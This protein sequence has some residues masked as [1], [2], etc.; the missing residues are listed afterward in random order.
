MTRNAIPVPLQKNWIGDRSPD[1][2]H[3]FSKQVGEDPDVLH[4]RL[5]KECPVALQQSEVGGLNEG[6]LVTRYEDITAVAADTETFGQSIRWPEQRRPPLESNPPEHRAFRALMQPFFMPRALAAFEPLSTELAVGLLEPL[7]AAGGGDLATEVARPLPPQVLLARL[8]APTEDWSG[9]KDA[10]EAAFL[11]GAPSPE[12][13][14]HYEQA[15]GFLW[16]Y[17]RKLV[18]ERIAS[19]R[20]SKSDLVS[21]VLAGEIDGEPVDRGLVE[22]MVRLVLAAGHDST[23]S[24]LG[25]CLKYLA[26][27]QDAQESLRRDPGRIPGAIEEMLRLEAPVVRMPRVVRQDTELHGRQL[28]KGDQ[29]L[30]VFASGN[31]DES[32]FENP[33]A[34]QFDRMPNR[35]LAFGVGV[36]VCIGNGLARQEIKVTLREL[37]ARTRRFELAGVAEREFWHP[38]GSTSLPVRFTA[39]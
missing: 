21:A 17:S 11:Q 22:G 31:R 10:C 12:D 24:A 25:I 4:A 9:I 8:N 18:A 2:V 30:M 32:E 37:L 13:I 39:A 6:W 16:D 35:H 15:N 33:D 34:C 14:A 26:T 3:E 28:R 5:R 27:H 36:H 1:L 7:I 20:E 19:P 38:Y 23:T 29:V